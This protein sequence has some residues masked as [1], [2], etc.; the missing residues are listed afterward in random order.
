[1][2][3]EAICDG[4]RQQAWKIE[5]AKDAGAAKLALVDHAFSA[6]LLDIGLPRESG[7][8]V[9]KWLR[10]RYDATPVLILTA[11]ERWSDKVAG[12][13]AGADDYVAKPFHM[14]EVLARVR[15]GAGFKLNAGSAGAWIDNEFRKPPG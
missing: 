7:L 6:I 3:A 13:D 1:M 14:E 8:T 9:L 4:V 15:V 11:R 12:M 10:E 2:L 5:H